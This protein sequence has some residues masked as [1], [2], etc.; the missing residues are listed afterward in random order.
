L[1]DAKLYNDL[2]RKKIL[3]WNTIRSN[4]DH[5]RFGRNSP[6]DVANMLEGV[7]DFLAEFLRS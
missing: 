5:G 7:R 6:S 3:V 1:A 2:W 4:A